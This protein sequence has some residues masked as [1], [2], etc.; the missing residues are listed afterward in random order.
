[1]EFTLRPLRQ[2]ISC[3]VGRLVG[4]AS[5]IGILAFRSN[6][7]SKNVDINSELKALLLN[8]VVVGNGKK[9]IIDDTTLTTPPPGFDSVSIFGTGFWGAR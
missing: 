1:M 8:K 3:L 5:D 9:L 7:Y 4:Y 2:S 6:D